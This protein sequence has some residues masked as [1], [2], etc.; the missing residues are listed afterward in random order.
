M[1]VM[2][3]SGSV[4]RRSSSPL[5]A[6]TRAVKTGCN[7]CEHHLTHTVGMSMCKYNC[8]NLLELILGKPFECTGKED[9]PHI[10]DD[11]T[12]FPDSS[13]IDTRVSSVIL[14]ALRQG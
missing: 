2:G 12:V 1:R 10:Y 7:H 5:I 6:A 9:L 4:P 3:K 8:R 14:S 11:D 13:K